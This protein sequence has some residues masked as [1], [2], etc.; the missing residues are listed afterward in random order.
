MPYQ[1]R[2]SDRYGSFRN[3]YR[4]IGRYRAADADDIGVKLTI[5]QLMHSSYYPIEKIL[6]KACWKSRPGFA[7]RL[8]V[9]KD[10]PAV[11]I[12]NIAPIPIVPL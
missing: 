12:N 1:D 10:L 4:V 6:K 3:R 8:D 7:T 9:D 2:I 11:K 5:C